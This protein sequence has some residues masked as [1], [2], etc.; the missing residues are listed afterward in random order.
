[1]QIDGWPVFLVV[2]GTIRNVKSY[3][4]LCLQKLRELKARGSSQ[5]MTLT[6]PKGESI[7][8]RVEPMAQAM[9]MTLIAPEIFHGIFGTPASSASP[10]GFGY[11]LG[12]VDGGTI[13]PINGTWGTPGVTADTNSEKPPGYDGDWIPPYAGGQ[14]WQVGV[15][16]KDGDRSKAPEL[17]H[18][19]GKWGDKIVRGGG[20]DAMGYWKSRVYGGP[21]AATGLIPIGKK[22]HDIDVFSVRGASPTWI[23]RGVYKA[24]FVEINEHA[25][26]R[27]AQMAGGNIHYEN[28]KPSPVFMNGRPIDFKLQDSTIQENSYVGVGVATVDASGG[29]TKRV[30]VVIAAK[31]VPISLAFA[32]TYQVCY[33]PQPFK[34]LYLAQ[35]LSLPGQVMGY[36]APITFYF[37]RSCTKASGIRYQFVL[38]DGGDFVPDSIEPHVVHLNLSVALDSVSATPE[39]EECDGCPITRTTYD[40]GIIG[41][42]HDWYVNYAAL[43]PNWARAN[44]NTGDYYGSTSSAGMSESIGPYHA[45]IAI[46]YDGD[47]EKRLTVEYSETNSRSDEQ[48][49]ISVYGRVVGSVPYQWPTEVAMGVVGSTRILNDHSSR[50]VTHKINGVTVQS[51]TS[52][53][54]RSL[55]G[56][57]PPNAVYG[58]AWGIFFCQPAD[59]YGDPTSAKDAYM[60]YVR[61]QYPDLVARAGIYTEVQEIAGERLTEVAE[62]ALLRDTDAGT[63]SV[64]LGG[65]WSHAIQRHVWIGASDFTPIGHKRGSYV[66][67]NILAVDLINDKL[68]Y[69]HVEGHWYWPWV[70]G[71]RYMDTGGFD[72]ASGSTSVYQIMCNNQV[73]YSG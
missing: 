39:I 33:S 67:I 37:N 16:T 73:L 7:H 68:Y 59:A 14:R 4:P 64:V 35:E 69:E 40:S 46:G 36:Q 60:D 58:P 42:E 45:T 44:S 72:E 30:L 48:S 43:G 62:I 53:S 50:T 54:E 20:V 47:T 9:W 25:Q 51:Y 66:G 18:G 19:S 28:A 24:D 31:L 26:G 57:H 8:L 2:K 23:C 65:A 12:F 21:V 49:S 61:A 63:V 41:S 70:G 10:N 17:V 56:S 11:P 32:G 71:F 13:T 34:K 3:V 15:S 27:Q 5:T 38:R 1:M 22:D 55:D 52:T 29:V 6:G